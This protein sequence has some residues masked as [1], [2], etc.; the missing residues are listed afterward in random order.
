[1]DIP[2]PDGG[3]PPANVLQEFLNLCE[4]EFGNLRLAAGIVASKEVTIIDD[5]GV[6][7]VHCVAGL[8]RAPV[9]CF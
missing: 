7:A 3:I 6:V 5:V 8:G 9:V 4:R 2:Y 1:M